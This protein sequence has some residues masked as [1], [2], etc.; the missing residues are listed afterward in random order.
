VLPFCLLASFDD[1]PP[2]W[3]LDD[4][5]QLAG[6]HNDE[7]EREVSVKN[8]IAVFRG[9][10]SHDPPNVDFVYAEER[11]V[12]WLEHDVCEAGLGVRGQCDR[13][14]E[15]GKTR[16]GGCGHINPKR[17]IKVRI[18]GS[19]KGDRHGASQFQESGI[20]RKDDRK[21]KLLGSNRFEWAVR[22]C[23]GGH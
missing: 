15:S 9:M 10:S 14:K 8:K 5:P 21:A 7:V 18:V 2:A 16:N 17:H 20:G 19:L 12:V 11:R 23:N 1:T 3:E 13:E 6:K 22:S 4:F